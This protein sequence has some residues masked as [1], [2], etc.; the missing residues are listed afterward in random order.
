MSHSIQLSDGSHLYYK[1]WGSGP[2]VVFS[3]GWPL[4]SDAFEDQMLFLANQGFRTIAFD[5]RGHGRSCQPWNGHNIDQYAQ[6]L[7]EAIEQLKLDEITLVGHSTG[8]A[9]VTRYTTRFGQG[10][11][12]KLVLLA[13]VTPLMIKRD[14]H[15][16]GVEAKVFDDIR[17]QVLS[18]RSDFYLSFAKT[19]YGYDKLLNKTSEGIIQNFW[20][21]AMQ[22]S[23]KAQYDC[24]SAFSETDLR[25][26]LHQI[27]I[28]TL[29][30]YGDAD[31]IVPPEVCSQAALKIL[32]NGREKV[33]QG[34]PHGLCSTHKNEV[35]QA[36][37]EF[38]N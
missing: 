30:L 24:V 17:D 37:L 5:R 23:I 1:D 31:T 26:D 21:I 2:V 9:V 8:G 15:P 22:G 34:A 18:N 14:D 10:K 36:L 19:F 38:L 6:D 11:V 16:E 3:H 33:I 25:Q 28:P 29:V 12:K 7:H 27:H 35:N 32:S 4:S 20:R 13:S